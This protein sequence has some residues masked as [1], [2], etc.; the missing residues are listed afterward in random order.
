MD[1]ISQRFLHKYLF[2]AKEKVMRI[3]FSVAVLCCLLS[4]Y[5][6][7]DWQ[8]IWS[9]EF[10]D[11]G[12]P[13]N[14][15]WG[16]ETGYV[17]NQEAQYYTNARAENARAE[18]GVLI[19]EARK[20]NWQGH[21]YTS[22]SLTTKNKHSWQYGRFE[23]KARINTQL[24]MWPAFWSMGITNRWP[25]CGEVDIMEYYQQTILANAFWSGSGGTTGNSRTL[26]LTAFINR[27]PDWTSQFHVWRM[28]WNA[29]SMDIFLDDMPINRIDLTTIVNYG[30]DFNPFR[31]PHYIIINL[32]IGGTMGGSLTNAVFPARYE[33]DYVRIYQDQPTGVIDTPGPLR[34]PGQVR[35]HNGP[36][37]DHVEF[38]FRNL[39]PGQPATLDIFDAHGRIISQRPRAAGENGSF[40]WNRAGAQAGVYFYT[41]HSA[42]A[43]DRGSFV[44][45]K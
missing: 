28:D 44:I 32:A 23:M 5:T 31:Q 43:A 35:R 17:R 6:R 21:E 20:D 1:T 14:T 38:I 42:G 10:D 40:R 33:V 25:A 22:A 39:L 8:L 29:N 13:D 15:K 11:T 7:A 41:L 26:P 36:D 9:D 30:T 16:Y 34:R 37:Q 2:L 4:G 19:I 3:C 45:F 27:D 24:G 12:L 18:N